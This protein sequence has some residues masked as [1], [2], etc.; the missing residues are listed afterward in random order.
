MI[1]SNSLTSSFEAFLIF[2]VSLVDD[3]STLILSFRSNPNG[4]DNSYNKRYC[5]ANSLFSG[6]E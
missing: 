6:I 2:T 5:A 4:T 1:A 3:L